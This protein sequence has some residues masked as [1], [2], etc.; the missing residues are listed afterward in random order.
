MKPFVV[1]IVTYLFAISVFLF[2]ILLLARQL[3]IPSQSFWEDS[4]LTWI[5]FGAGLV[6]AVGNLYRTHRLERQVAHL[7]KVDRLSQYCRTIV[8]AIHDLNG[9]GQA[10]PQLEQLGVHVWK[11]V[12]TWRGHELKCI[13]RFKLAQRQGSSMRWTKGKGVIG[14]AWQ[15]SSP[16]S[17]DMAPLIEK[18]KDVAAFSALAPAS[19]LNL[20]AEEFARINSYRSVTAFPIGRKKAR[21]C[22]SVDST[23]ADVHDQIAASLQKATVQNLLRAIRISMGE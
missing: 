3:Q 5:V 7:E 2:A 18:A 20:S 1:T 13:A 14:R 4:T 8:N 12:R 10:G 23:Q 21:G 15:L 16:A 19:R 9:A 6:A 22:I 11:V 17:L